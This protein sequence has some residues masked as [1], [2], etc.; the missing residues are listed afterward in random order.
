MCIVGVKV[1]LRRK[2]GVDYGLDFWDWDFVK[3]YENFFCEWWNYK[4]KVSWGFVESK[5]WRSWEVCE[6]IG[7]WN[8]C[9]VWGDS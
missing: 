8:C 6:D 7:W 2:R 9:G 5:I 3:C 4:G 1:F